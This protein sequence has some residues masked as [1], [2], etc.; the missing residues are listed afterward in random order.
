M[1]HHIF[2]I[3]T[4][5]KKPR[6]NLINC[7]SG[8]IIECSVPLEGELGYNNVSIG[9]PVSLGKNGVKKIIEPILAENEKRDLDIAVNKIKEHINNIY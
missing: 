4:L 8:K 1:Q 3:K 5:E 2:Y 6:K 9:M 7:D